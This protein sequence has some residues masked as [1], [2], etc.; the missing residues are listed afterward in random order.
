MGKED[1]EI[2]DVFLTIGCWDLDCS[3]RNT[4]AVAVSTVLETEVDLNHMEGC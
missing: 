1:K 3:Y 2:V 4:V